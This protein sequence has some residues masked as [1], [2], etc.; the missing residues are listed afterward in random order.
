MYDCC[1]VYSRLSIN[2]NSETKEAL[3][4]LSQRDEMSVTEVVR[5]AVGVY[6]YASDEVKKGK[7]LQLVDDDEIITLKLV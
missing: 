7:Q 2:I 6:K 5:H 1:M 4:D 3:Q